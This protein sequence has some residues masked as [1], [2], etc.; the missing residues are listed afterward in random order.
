MMLDIR[1][2]RP[3]STSCSEIRHLVYKDLQIYNFHLNYNISEINLES[4]R[5]IA[6]T[7]SGNSSRGML[8]NLYVL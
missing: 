5:Q 2:K 8:G 3:I 1:S 7:C 6:R 4:K